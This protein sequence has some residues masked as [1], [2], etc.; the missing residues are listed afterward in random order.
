[1][2]DHVGVHVTDMERSVRFYRDVLGLRES[3]RFRMADETLTFLAAAGGW[4]E[5]IQDGMPRRPTGVV[6][7]VALRVDDV[8]SMLARMRAHGVQVLDEE[9]IE[10]PEINARIAF[11]TGPDGERIELIERR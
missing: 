9:A 6:D 10:V 5:L 4:L 3:V 7:H 1:V 2:L 11:C 8:A